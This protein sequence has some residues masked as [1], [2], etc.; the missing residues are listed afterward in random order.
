MKKVLV[1]IL[2]LA[3]MLSCFCTINVFADE[4]TPTITAKNAAGEVVGTYSTIDT[5]ANAAGVNGTVVLSEGTFEFNGRQTIA[6]EG[7][8]L[9]G[10]GK[11]VTFIKT[12]ANFV[13]ASAT[14]K[15]ALLTITANNVT[16]KD[17]SIDASLYGNSINPAVDEFNVVRINSGTGIVLDDI[18]VTGSLRTLISIG[19]GS[20]SATVTATDLDC[21]AAYKSIPKHTLTTSDSVFADIDITKG[22]FTLNSGVVN[23]FIRA[24][25]GTTFT[26]N[27]A[28]GTPKYYNL[29]Q[30]FIIVKIIDVTTTMHHFIYSYDNVCASVSS[31]DFSTFNNVVRANKAKI[32]AMTTEAVDLDDQELIGKF[33]DMLDDILAAGSDSDLSDCRATLAQHYHG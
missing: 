23:G 31:D 9:E 6:V 29:V 12:S 17:L 32:Q 4:I 2:A 22:S 10:A 16:V 5:A 25:S 30:R 28:S 15:K 13:N 1:S 20:A 18:Y 3:M 11:G 27:A 26:N 33:I 19:S 8:T 7:I 14:N 21:Q 24:D